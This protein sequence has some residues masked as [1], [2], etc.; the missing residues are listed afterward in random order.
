VILRLA[1]SGRMIAHYCDSR[2]KMAFQ[3]DVRGHNNA[4]GVFLEMS[5]VSE[6]I[7]Y[8]RVEVHWEVAR[9]W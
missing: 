4:L 2:M 8:R 5:G 3:F 6:Q 1:L 7:A 9:P